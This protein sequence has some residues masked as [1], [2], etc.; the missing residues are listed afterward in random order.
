MLEPDDAVRFLSTALRTLL[1]TPE[2]CEA[3]LLAIFANM[4]LGLLIFV[5]S[6]LVTSWLWDRFMLRN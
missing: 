4:I 6:A 3:S 2:S 5:V 1:S